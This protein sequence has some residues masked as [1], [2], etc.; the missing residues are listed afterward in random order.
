RGSGFGGSS[1]PSPPATPPDW[2]RPP[3]GGSVTFV[4][5]AEGGRTVHYLDGGYALLAVGPGEEPPAA[6]VSSSRP[7]L[8]AAA[9]P[10]GKIAVAGLDRIL[11][12]VLPGAD[13]PGRWWL[14]DA[15]KVEVL[16]AASGGTLAWVA[17]DGIRV[18]ADDGKTRARLPPA[19]ERTLALAWQR[20]AEWLFAA[21]AA[22]RLRVFDRDLRK[23]WEATVH[24][25]RAPA[26]DVDP[27]GR[28]VATGGWDGRVRVREIGRWQ[29]IVAELS[30][31][32]RVNAVRFSPSGARLA[33]A[34]WGDRVLVYDT[35]TWEP[36]LSL[37]GPEGGTLSLGFGPEESWLAGGGVDGSIRVWQLSR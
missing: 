29:N 32:F 11:R 12:V 30:P 25:D 4:Y 36:A 19:A 33:V 5:P 35:R 13:R 18:V 3:S 26:L 16:A 7:I 10:E 27:A 17:G 23:A 21:D 28:W 1:G 22:G 15:G 20:E 9:L 8:A 31:G 14:L 6:A 34:G 24:E 2:A 37:A